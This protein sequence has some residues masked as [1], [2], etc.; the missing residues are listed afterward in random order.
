MKEL[1]TAHDGALR[2]LFMFG[3]R[4]H[5][6]L[7]LGGDKTGQRNAWYSWAVPAA[8]DLYATYLDGLKDEGLI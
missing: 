1:R 3:P 6:I 7:L 2:V 4:W 5:A 8:D